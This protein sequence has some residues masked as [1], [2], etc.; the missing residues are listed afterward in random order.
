MV[1]AVEFVA[2]VVETVVEFV[3][4]VAEAVVEFGEVEVEV[5]VVVEFVGVV[6]EAVVEFVGVAV[7][8][9]IEVVVGA[10]LVVVAGVEIGM[11]PLVLVG[12]LDAAVGTEK[13]LKTLV[14]VLL[15]EEVG[16]F[17]VAVVVGVGEAVR[18]Y[19]GDIVK[20]TGDTAVGDD[21]AQCR[22]EL[23]AR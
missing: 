14:V 13:R 18:V 16:L 10:E 5:E 19:V 11:K 21:M 7:E 12:Q 17:V 2:A 4:V 1:S 23:A 15:K 6:V 3:E 9:V 22:M 20:D 8:A